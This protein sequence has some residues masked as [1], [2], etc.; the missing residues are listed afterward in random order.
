MQGHRRLVAATAIAAALW[1]PAAALAQKT[2]DPPGFNG[3][4]GPV[5][6]FYDEYKAGT[7]SGED[8]QKLVQMRDD[9]VGQVFDNMPKNASRSGLTKD[10]MNTTMSNVAG[11][12]TDAVRAGDSQ[13]AADA[14]ISG[15]HQ[16]TTQV[17]IPAT[18][19]AGIVVDDLTDITIKL[20]QKRGEM[21]GAVP[22]AIDKQVNSL[23]MFKSAADANLY[24][25]R[26]KLQD[27]DTAAQMDPAIRQQL[28]DKIDAG[29]KSGD[30]A[31]DADGNLNVS[32]VL[33]KTGGMASVDG[34]GMPGG[35]NGNTAPGSSN[36]GATGTGSHS[37]GGNTDAGATAHTASDN[38][39]ASN[40]EGNGASS[41]TTAGGDDGDIVITDHYKL[42]GKGSATYTGSD[43]K[44]G[45][46]YI[47]HTDANGNETRTPDPDGGGGDAGGGSGG[48]NGI[49]SGGGSETADA[50]NELTGG[51]TAFDA[52]YANYSFVDNGNGDAT[53]AVPSTQVAGPSKAGNSPDTHPQGPSSAMNSGSS[54]GATGPSSAM[55]SGSSAGVKGP[56]SAMTTGSSAGVTGPSSAL[57]GPSSALTGPSTQITGPSS[58]LGANA[59]T[60]AGP[61]SGG[62]NSYM[63]SNQDDGQPSLC[64]R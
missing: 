5:G 14:A 30:I 51:S 6:K 42:D 25:M 29:M 59:N 54:S 56:S 18:I 55:N 16:V 23:Q 31:I 60:P 38:G 44:P 63:A 13:A 35:G 2:P 53:V 27:A 48:E 10:A 12:F 34:N 3:R 62:D 57:N 1:L 32:A 11:E 26:Q 43:Y 22:D 33:K 52:I 36:N 49:W 7:L 39:A 28:T 19:Q 64:G 50:L 8:Y 15:N 46:G 47:V 4:Y 40:T 37:A 21:G 9:L 61:Q 45:N 41:G 20:Y 58:V 24:V 17:A